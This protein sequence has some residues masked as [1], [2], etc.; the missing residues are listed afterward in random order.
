MNAL[1]EWQLEDIDFFREQMAKAEVEEDDSWVRSGPWS[2]RHGIEPAVSE[3]DGRGNGYPGGWAARTRISA[4]LPSAS[5]TRET[6]I[7]SL[8][9]GEA[10]PGFSDISLVPRRRLVITSPLPPCAV[11]VSTLG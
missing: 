8:T 10:E 4:W 5:T 11:G 3:T 6:A 9:V 1:C 2:V 7:G